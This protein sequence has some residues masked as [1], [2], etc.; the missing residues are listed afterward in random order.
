MNPAAETFASASASAGNLWRTLARQLARSGIE[1]AMLD[2][3]ILLRH[4]TGWS[5]ETLSRAPETALDALQQRHLAALGERRC[6]GVPVARLT[7][8]KEFWS[9]EF[10]LSDETLVPRPE[11]ETLIEAALKSGG[12]D[13]SLRLLDLGTG[14]G[15]LLLS[16]L[17]EYRNSSGVGIDISAGATATAQRNAER[18]GIRDRARFQTG[19]WN[20]RMDNIIGERFDILVSNPPYIRSADIG[21]LQKE[22]REHDPQVALDGGS[23]GMD[24]VRTIIAA[25]PKLLRPN[26]RLL[27]EIGAGQSGEIVSF[28]EKQ[29]FEKIRKHKDLAGID[30]VIEGV[31]SKTTGII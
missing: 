7:G 21:S 15:C 22:V 20:M 16:L 8:H 27:I 4:V 11:S 3:E 6:R 2:A 13:D 24:S 26:G 9:L 28:M 1:T 14:C 29:T 19:N 31:S 12:R 5:R 10:S 25:A 17:H 23:D 18:L 30:R